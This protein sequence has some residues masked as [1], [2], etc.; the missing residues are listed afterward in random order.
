LSTTTRTITR[1]E[2]RHDDHGKTLPLG[3]QAQPTEHFEPVHLREIE[4]KNDRVDLLRLVKPLHAQRLLAAIEK[5]RRRLLEAF[6]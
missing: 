1:S 2:L 3:T 5:G 6:L 4:I